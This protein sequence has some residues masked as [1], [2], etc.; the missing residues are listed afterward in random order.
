MS[1]NQPGTLAPG[2]AQRAQ[3]AQAASVDEVSGKAPA[4]VFVHGS[5]N[6]ARTWDAVIAALPDFQCIALDLPGHGAQRERPGPEAMSVADYADFVHNELTRRGLSAVCLIGH[7]LGGGIALRLAVDHPADV[8][9]IVSVGS[10]AR[11]RVLPSLLQGAKDTPAETWPAAVVAGFAPGHAEQAHAY[12]ATML[13][14]APGVLYRDYN[15]CDHFD[16][17][18][19]LARVSQPALAIVGDQDT[20]TPPKYSIYLRDHLSDTQLVI[21]HNA[22]HYVHVEHPTA[23]AEAIRDWL[24]ASVRRK[25]LGFSPRD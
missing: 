14:F 4:L 25:P 22:G 12:F 13:P 23:V 15:A 6:S 18:D 1:E 19:E 20:A 9:R 8:G 11:L 7:S 3:Q 24:T 10:G 16:M 5:G 17:M 2:Q 21:V